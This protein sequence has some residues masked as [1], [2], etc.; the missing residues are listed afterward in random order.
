MLKLSALSLGTPLLFMGL[1]LMMSDVE[2]IL[3][4]HSMSAAGGYGLLSGSVFAVVGLSFLWPL[5]PFTNHSS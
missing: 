3:R 4:Q 5:R 1:V 2:V